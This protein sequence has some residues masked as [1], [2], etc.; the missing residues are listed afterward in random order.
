MPV[1]LADLDFRS[2]L[3]IQRIDAGERDVLAE[4]RRAHR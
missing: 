1:E 3:G 2:E 4:D